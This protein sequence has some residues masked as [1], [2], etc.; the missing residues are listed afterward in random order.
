MQSLHLGIDFCSFT[1]HAVLNAF[2][3]LHS[4]LITD[5]TCI[6][7]YISFFIRTREKQT[8]TVLYRFLMFCALLALHYMFLLKFTLSL[9]LQQTLKKKL[10]IESVFIAEH[11][12][13]GL[14]SDVG[15]DRYIELEGYGLREIEAQD[16]EKS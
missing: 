7:Y 11:L 5:Y 12:L 3:K 9:S 6:Y 2:Y 15:S 4:K 16:F 8:F 14:F 13:S 10:I 1:T